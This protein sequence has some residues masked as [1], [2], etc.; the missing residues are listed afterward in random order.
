MTDRRS[1]LMKHD[2]LKLLWLPQLVMLELHYRKK[3]VCIK[4]HKIMLSL[5]CII[6]IKGIS[7]R[8]QEPDGLY[9][10]SRG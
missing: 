7:S 10:Q 1:T 2:I 8:G 3:V 5:I 6:I 9:R 4:L